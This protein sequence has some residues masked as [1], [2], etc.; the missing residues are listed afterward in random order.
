LLALFF[1]FLFSGLGQMLIIER[2]STHKRCNKRE[3]PKMNSLQVTTDAEHPARAH[4]QAL[5]Q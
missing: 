3:T 4:T 2:A 1:V 5:Q